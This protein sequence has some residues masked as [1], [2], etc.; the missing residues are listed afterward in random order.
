MIRETLESW[1]KIV[2]NVF[3]YDLLLAIFRV[4]DSRLK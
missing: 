4:N 3:L 1:T 2:H